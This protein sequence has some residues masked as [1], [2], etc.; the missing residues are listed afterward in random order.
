MVLAVGELSVSMSLWVMVPKSSRSKFVMVP[1][2]LLVETKEQQTARGMGLATGEQAPGNHTP[3][4]PMPE[5]LQLVTYLGGWVMMSCML[6]GQ[7]VRLHVSQQNL[8][9][10]LWVA[11]WRYRQLPDSR[12]CR[13]S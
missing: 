4:I 11:A 10:K 12:C 5:A 9:R 1:P 8:S 7:L 3:P 6:V 2:G 13:A